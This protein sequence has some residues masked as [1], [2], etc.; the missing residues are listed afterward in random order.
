MLT[1]LLNRQF[2]ND[3]DGRLGAGGGLTLMQIEL[4]DFKPVNDT[5]G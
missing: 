1:G 3:F 2:S 5:L 4:D